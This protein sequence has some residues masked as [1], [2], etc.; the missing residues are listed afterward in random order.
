MTESH[1]RGLFYRYVPHQWPNLKDGF[2]EALKVESDGSVQWIEITNHLDA[3]IPNREKVNE[4][5][6]MAGGM[7]CWYEKDSVY[8]S[9][10]LDNRVHS[11]NLSSNRYEV[12]WDGENGRQ[13]LTGIDDLTVDPLTGDVFVAE[14]NGNMELVVI[15]PEGSVEPFCRVSGSQHD[16]SALTGP[17]F[18]PFRKRLYIS[19]QRAEGNRLVRDVIPAINWGVGSYGSRTGVTYEI[20]GP[21]RTVKISDTSSTIPIDIPTTPIDAPTTTLL[22]DVSVDIPNETIPQSVPEKKATTTSTLKLSAE[23]VKEKNIKDGKDVEGSNS[24]LV[25]SS[26]IGVAIFLGAGAAAIK[27]RSNSLMKSDKTP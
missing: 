21:F 23:K 4:G 10:R 13:P 25:I 27:Y 3:T 19:S 9:T 2:L 1:R 15:T 26:F 7:G 24:L 14:T 5:K 20:S 22:Q 16:F 18:D 17:C 6:L 12:I 8:F 11:I